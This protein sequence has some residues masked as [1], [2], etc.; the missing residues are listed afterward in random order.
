MQSHLARALFI[1]KKRVKGS[2][3]KPFDTHKI[4]GILF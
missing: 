1:Q 3:H 2:I 4:L